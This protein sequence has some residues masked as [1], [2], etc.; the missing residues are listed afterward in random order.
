MSKVFVTAIGIASACGRGLE[1]HARAAAGAHT[2]LKENTFFNGAPPDPCISGTIPPEILAD[3][4]RENGPVRANRLLEI[5]CADLFDSARIQDALVADAIVGTTLGNMH[6]GTEYYQ[7]IRKKGPGD[8][9]LIEYFS[10][11][12]PL[13]AL[14]RTFPLRGKYWTVSS[15]C[16]SGSAAL[17][18]AMER[19]RCGLSDRIVAGGVDALSPYVVAGFNSLRLI[20]RDFCRPFDARRDGLNPGEAAALLLLESE[21]SMVAAGRSPLA[22]LAGYGEALEAYH[23]TRANPEGTGVASAISKA[24]RAG[25]IGPDRIDHIHLHGTA[26]VANDLSEYMACAHIFGD[27]LKDIPLC[28]TKSMT[29]HTFGAAGAVAAVFSVISIDRGIIAP[30]LFH[31]ER[32]AAFELLQVSNQPLQRPQTSAVL[33]TAL[34]FG[35]EAFALVLGKPGALWN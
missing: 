23:M 31:Q 13:H 8:L 9:S 34:G 24:L 3:S 1:S 27:R 21:E 17:G 16:G 2:G 20:S 5:A 25:R 33:T 12:G 7:Q 6:G 28:S 29:G 11:C 35:G 19:I 10:P 30:T 14:Y 32:D 22:E 18:M 15:A 26:T 4:F